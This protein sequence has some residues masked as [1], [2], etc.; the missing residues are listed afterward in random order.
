MNDL[1][2]RYLY[3]VTKRMKAGLREDVQKELRT[4]IDDMLAE[5]CGDMPPT[6]RDVRVVL[7]ELGSPREMRE[8]YEG[9]G[10]RCLIGQPHYAMYIFVLRIVL[11][12]GVAGLTLGLAMEQLMDPQGW[13]D[14]VVNWL[15]TLWS[16]MLSAFA[17]VTILFAVLYRKGV[18][19]DHD[20]SLDQLPPVPKK[21]QQIPVWEPVVG[22]VVSVLFF[23]AFLW[24]PQVFCLIETDTGITTPLF[25][26]A[27]VRKGWYLIA[28]WTVC[29]VTR[30][31]VKLMERRYCPAVALTTVITNSASALFGI[32]WGTQKGLINPA[33]QERLA[34]VLR[35][36]EPEDRETITRLFGNDG[37]MLMQRL[38]WFI[39]FIV[40]MVLVIDAVVTVVKSVRK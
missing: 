25:D 17:F 20:E 35:N 3:A 9:S 5:R 30:E 31:V 16:A 14:A 37:T 26:V 1:I 29:G 8:K 4:L 27:V 6:E 36:V 21:K 15:S 18:K 19:L 13:Y 2:E 38:L 34:Q 7:T 11:I 12:A 22:I 28:L 40:V 39:L 33:V 10:D 32:L 24:V 23:V